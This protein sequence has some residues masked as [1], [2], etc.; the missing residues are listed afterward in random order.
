MGSSNYYFLNTHKMEKT[1]ISVVDDNADILEIIKVYFEV[2]SEYNFR[3]YQDAVLFL[4][5]L[6]VELDLVILDVHMPNFNI[7]DAV[8]MIDV[9]SP[10]AYVI[11]L[12]ADR[13]WDTM[14]QL[15]NLGIFRYCEKGANFLE[16][17]SGAI[18]AAHTKITA[19]KHILERMK[20]LTEHGS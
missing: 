2:N 11:V 1:S 8:K 7:V 14:K 18:A 10:M 20:G 3:Y 9:R 19:R 15:A 17:L 16:E 5:E 12:S 4:E 13:V 6:D